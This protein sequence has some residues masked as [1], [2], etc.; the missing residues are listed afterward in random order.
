MGRDRNERRHRKTAANPEC[1]AMMANADFDA[2]PSLAEAMGLVPSDGHCPHDLKVD[3]DGTV[4]CPKCGRA[5]RMVDGWATWEFRVRVHRYSFKGGYYAT[6]DRVPDG[7]PLCTT[8]VFFG[9][10]GKQNAIAAAI[11]E[12]RTGAPASNDAGCPG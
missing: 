12:A 1:V 5:G 7:K 4:S 8:G 10:G 2:V 9:K 11:H 3:S 6:A